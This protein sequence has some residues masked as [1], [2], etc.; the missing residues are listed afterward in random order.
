MA[1]SIDLVGNPAPLGDE[2]QPRTSIRTCD[3]P[4]WRSTLPARAGRWIVLSVSPDLRGAIAMKPIPPSPWHCVQRGQRVDAIRVTR[5]CLDCEME[6]IL[7]DEWERELLG[8]LPVPND[9]HISENE[10]P[11]EIHRERTPD[12]I[13]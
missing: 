11:S 8:P 3:G 4:D 12:F 2:N 7:E 10:R 9:E 5:R 6:L 13:G 1:R